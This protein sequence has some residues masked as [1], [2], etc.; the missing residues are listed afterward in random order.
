MG[1]PSP[2]ATPVGIDAARNA[3]DA[4]V[5]ARFHPRAA[6]GI[7]RLPSGD[8]VF[9][10]LP[11][12]LAA[13]TAS[14]RWILV[15]EA[16]TIDLPVAEPATHLVVAHLVDTWR[17]DDGERPAGLAVGH[18][19]PIGE[20]L[21]RYTVADAAGGRRTR[22]VRR[23]FEINDGLLGW[24]SAAFAAVPHLENEV[25]DWRG[26]H[27]PQGVGRYAPAGQSGVLTIMPGTYGGDQVGMTDFVPNAT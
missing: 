5:I 3:T 16:L 25:L 2:L 8:Q 12:Q 11:F 27:A 1:G 7:R 21:A 24:G 23:R 22:I 6:A 15:R 9:H 18:V 10:G 13:G 17:D 26:P 20:P 4:D 19:V 14:R